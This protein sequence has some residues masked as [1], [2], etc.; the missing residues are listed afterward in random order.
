MDADPA[1]EQFYQG[2]MRCYA[3]LDRRSEAIAAYQR[4][5]RTLSVLLAIKP[6]A[7]TEKLYQTLR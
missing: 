1:I 3:K 4:L 2:L 7:A 6:S 5:K